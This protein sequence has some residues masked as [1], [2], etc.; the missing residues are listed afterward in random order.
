MKSESPLTM[1][2]SLNLLILALLSYPIAESYVVNISLERTTRYA[3]NWPRLRF[4]KLS[5][6]YLMAISNYATDKL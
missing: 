5:E 2:I 1:L 3:M 4:L 6:Y